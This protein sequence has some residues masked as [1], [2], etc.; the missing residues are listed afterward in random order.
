M[1]EHELTPEDTAA[2]R[3]NPGDW[4]EYLRSEMNRGR[5][6]RN[7]PTPAQAPAHPERQP[8][9]WPPGTRPPDPPPL[10]PDAEVQRALAEYR[11]WLAAGCPRITTRCECQ[12][13]QQLQGG[14][15]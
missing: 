5:A 8:G 12:P 1:T 6:R 9:G 2:M 15:R 7:K 11:D 14:T 4:R 13:C 3:A 10:I